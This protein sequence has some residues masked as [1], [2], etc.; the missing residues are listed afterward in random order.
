MVS[1][2]P[3]VVADNLLFIH[4]WNTCDAVSA[5]YS[6]GKSKLLNVFER[7]PELIA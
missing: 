1:L 2:L 7:N 4:T 5:T 3:K 6:H